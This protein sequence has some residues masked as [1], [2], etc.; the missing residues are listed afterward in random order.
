MSKPAD[1]L[2]ISGSISGGGGLTKTGSGMLVLTG[3]NT[4]SGGTAITAAHS[5][6]ATAAAAPPSQAPLA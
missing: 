6:S 4:Y 2:T 1:A 5:R 3:S